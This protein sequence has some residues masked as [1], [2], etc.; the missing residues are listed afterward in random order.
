MCLLCQNDGQY[1]SG[2]LCDYCNSTCKRCIDSASNACTACYNNT[3]LYNG[4]CV[5]KCP[6]HYSPS[7]ATLTCVGNNPFIFIDESNLSIVQTVIPP[8]A[9]TVLSA[10]PYAIS[11]TLVASSMFSGHFSISLMMCLV[12]IES[13]ANMQYLNINHSS[14]ASSTYTSISSCFIPNWIAKFNTLP[15][16]EL[17]FEWGVFEQNQ[18]SSLYLDNYGDSMTEILIYFGVYLLTVLLIIKTTPEVLIKSFFGKVYVLA[19]SFFFSNIFGSIQSQIL[20]STLQFLGVELTEDRY[21]GISLFM[22]YST[23]LV[24]I[25]LLIGGFFRLRQ[26]SSYTSTYS[27]VPNDISIEAKMKARWMR[28]KYEFMHEDFKHSTKNQAFFLYWIVTF[29]IVYILIIFMFQQIPIAQCTLQVIWTLS[30]IILSGIVQPFKKTAIAVM[31]FFNFICILAVGVLNLAL[32][33]LQKYDSEFSEL[34]TQGWMV[35][36]IITTNTSTNG[37]YSIVILAIELYSKLRRRCA[38]KKNERLPAESTSVRSRI[39][40]H[41]SRREEASSR[42]EMGN[43]RLRNENPASQNRDQHLST[44]PERRVHSRRAFQI[45]ELNPRDI[46]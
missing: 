14:I 31:H 43:T 38:Q 29:N 1:I 22:G 46:A 25:G 41:N 8:A 33:V 6:T 44:R 23:L 20:F 19:L 32:A 27:Q 24:I 26:V 4:S 13:L 5:A 40:P 3:Y 30:F 10:A 35:T 15:Q 7:T 37:I 9:S 12:A 2:A 28:K 39:R 11:G 45:S 16:A 34:D 21:S 18:I 42:T 36:A 17:I